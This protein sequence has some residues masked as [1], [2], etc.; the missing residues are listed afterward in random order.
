MNPDILRRHC[1]GPRER[2]RPQEETRARH[3]APAPALKRRRTGYGFGPLG[4]PSRQPLR[5]QAGR[6]NSRRDPIDSTPRRLAVTG[7]GRGARTPSFGTAE[8]RSPAWHH[9][10][11]AEATWTLKGKQSP[12]KDRVAGRWQRRLVTTDSS[13]EQSLEVGCSVRFR[14]ARTSAHLGGC[15]RSA[16]ETPR[17]RQ[18][19]PDGSPRAVGRC[20]PKRPSGV[21][22][23]PGG[24][25]IAH[26]RHRRFG[27]GT[28]GQF[29]VTTTGA[30]APGRAACS[31]TWGS[32][33]ADRS[34][35]ASTP[36]PRTPVP[37]P[38][39]AGAPGHRDSAGGTPRGA[40]RTVP[41][42]Q[43]HPASSEAG[44]PRSTGARQTAPLGE[45][46]AEP[47]RGQATG[48]LRSIVRRASLGQGTSG[49]SEPRAPHPT[50]QGTASSSEPTAPHPTGQGTASSSEPTAP[51]PTG[52]GNPGL[53]GGAEPRSR[54]RP[55]PPAC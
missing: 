49:S 50:G 28:D 15:R 33:S 17:L 23:T 6:V 51:H 26:H 41:P 36:L 7:K 38:S 21:E 12:W 14:R 55:E 40:A 22:P 34:I 46:R 45:P 11:G 4:R 27:T 47:H 44:R 37:Q 3:R 9:R 29:H 42:G 20:T 5:R 16:T 10:D 24:G 19:N 43:G 52:T 35:I 31:M 13:A 54:P 32:A 18:R 8:E 25:S 48:A 39:R 53:F 1:S 2:L 30:S